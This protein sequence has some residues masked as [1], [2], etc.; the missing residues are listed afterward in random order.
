MITATGTFITGT[1]VQPG[2]K[3]IVHHALIYSV[4]SGSTIPPP[5]DGVPNQYDCFG[6][7]GVSNPSLVAAWAPGGLPY[8]YP[9]DVGHPI[10]VG[11]KFIMQVHYHPHA[12]ATMDPDT[13]TFQFTSTTTAPS[14]TVDTQLM[15]NYTKAVANG[16][17][18]EDPPFLIPPN[19]SA[20]VFTMDQTIPTLP[21]AVRLLSVAAHMHLV[22]TDEKITITRAN[23]DAS[24]PQD[25]C[26]LQVP[27]WNFNWQRS[28]EYDV[29]IG[30]LPTVNT[31]D[32]LKMRCTYN[33]TMQNPLL[34]ASLTEQGITQPQPVS[35][36]ETTN[37]E[38]CLGAYWFVYPT[39]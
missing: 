1:N 24:N 36:G 19:A 13:T 22:G 25:E 14:W 5:T 28:Y 23:P 34:A 15:G 8:Q 7:P 10:D 37:D 3:T 32:L 20:Q 38:M 16:S 30:S 11:T 27:S 31:G 18:L 9:M 21:I 29:D 6:G 39:L 33:N 26:L 4:P 2:N 35:L 17:G 12:N